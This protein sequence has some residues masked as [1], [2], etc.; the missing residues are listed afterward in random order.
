MSTHCKVG[1]QSNFGRI[2]FLLVPLFLFTAIFSLYLFTLCPTVGLIDAGEFIT[3]AKFLNILHP[4][5]YP[6]FSLISRL[7]S[8]LPLGNLA[9]RM[10]LLSALI[11]TFSALFFFLFLQKIHKRLLISFP[12]TFLYSFSLTVWSVSTEVEVYSLTALF[13][14]LILYF[15][16][17]WEERNSF[18]I[19]AFLFGLALTN[20]M[21]IISLLLASLLCGLFFYRHLFGK[22]FLFGLAF[23]FLGI[24]LYYFLILRASLNPLFNWGNPRDWTRFVWQITGKQYR[25]WMFSGSL[26][27]IGRNVSRGLAILLWDMLFILLPIALFGI[28]CAFKKSRELS[29]LFSILFLV[30]FFYAVN[31]SIPDIQ[32]YYLPSLFA[33]LFFLS[34]GLG[35]IVRVLRKRG[36]VVLLLCCLPVIFNFKKANKRD[37]YFAEDFAK[38]VFASAPKDAIIL[39]NWWDFYAPAFYLRYVEKHRPDLCIIDKELCRRLWYFLYL[40]KSYPWLVE[41]SC[42]ELEEFLSY[43]HQFEYGNLKDNIE[44]QNS[45]IRMLTSFLEKNPE[46]RHFFLFLPFWDPD[47]PQILKGKKAI[48]YGLLYEIREDSAYHFFDYRKLHFRKPKIPLGERE[49]IILRYYSFVSLERMRYLSTPQ[50][51]KREGIEIWL[52]KIRG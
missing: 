51:A 25:V 26:S 37:Y 13:C 46:R 18:L 48:P 40:K 9:W 11:S 34:F 3:G 43:L 21:M 32:P 19:I 41:R 38:N 27:E 5:G 20:H 28:I 39:T 17:R 4:T 29:F 42:R 6:L 15:I 22:F 45:F 10:N 47:L 14:S 36:Y 52:R 7:F 1:I 31:Y 2:K 24:S 30:S 8:F 35:E 33:L 44:I 49:K 16:S 12:V 50:A 23:F